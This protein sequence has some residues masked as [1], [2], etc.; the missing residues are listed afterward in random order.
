LQEYGYWATFAF[1]LILGGAVGNLIDRVRLGYVVD[2][3][4][5]RWFPVFN[6]ADSSIVCGVTVLVLASMFRSEGARR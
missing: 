2:F 6:L 1:G 5:F 3:I 4:D